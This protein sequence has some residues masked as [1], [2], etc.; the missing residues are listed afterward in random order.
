MSTPLNMWTYWRDRKGTVEAL[1]D[2]Y[3]EVVAQ[4]KDLQLALF[5]IKAA[6]ALIEKTM[7]S[8]PDD[9]EEEEDE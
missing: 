3:P 2:Y 9:S 6:V 8:L 1:E 5:Q 4:N 7:A